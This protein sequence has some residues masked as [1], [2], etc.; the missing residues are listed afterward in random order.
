M[1][2]RTTQWADTLPLESRWLPTVQMV[3]EQRRVAWSELR[4]DR[5]TAPRNGPQRIASRRRV[6][7]LALIGAL[8][9]AFGAGAAAA[10]ALRGWAG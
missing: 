1:S 10:L 8:L 5:A 6:A 9:A 4:R 7:D 3:E 2:S